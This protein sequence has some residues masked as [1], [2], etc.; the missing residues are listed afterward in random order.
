MPKLDTLSSAN[1]VIG[2][3]PGKKS[4][5]RLAGLELTHC[6]TLLGE[7]ED[8]RAIERICQ[9]MGVHWI[10]L[11]IAGGGEEALKAAPI[12]EYIDTVSAAIAGVAN[13]KIY[14]H[15]S[16][17]IHRTGYIAYIFLRIM[18]LD[19]P[20]ALQALRALR[21]VTADQIGEDRRLLAEARAQE[22]LKSWQ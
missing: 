15:C 5:D 16:A 3:R 14:L 9:R 8:P 20:A 1:L 22:Y 6:C 13:P 21:S 12:E 4:V 11:P 2:P 7:K 17:G 19:E 10:W 18:G